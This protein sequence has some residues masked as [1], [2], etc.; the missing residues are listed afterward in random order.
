MLKSLIEKNFMCGIIIIL[1]NLLEL[2]RRS[3]TRQAGFVFS[4]WSLRNLLIK[5]FWL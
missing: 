2:S 3:E 4:L 1:N 5:I